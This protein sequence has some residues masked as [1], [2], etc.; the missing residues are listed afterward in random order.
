MQRAM[1]ALAYV[2]QCRV[3]LDFVEKDVK[4][5]APVMAPTVTVT[6]VAVQ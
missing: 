4:Q 6:L 5:S 2:V 1:V 3:W